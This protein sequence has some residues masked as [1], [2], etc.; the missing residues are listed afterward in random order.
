MLCF[1]GCTEY[2]PVSVI[3]N[4]STV[5][6]IRKL[7]IDAPAEGR[8]QKSLRAHAAEVLQREVPNLTLVESMELADATISWQIFQGHMCVDCGDLAAKGWSWQGEL[9]ATHGGGLVMFSGTKPSSKC[10]PD[11]EFIHQLAKYLQAN[12]Q[13]P[14]VPSHGG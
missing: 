11:D 7:Y 5:L 14:F 8:D 2:Y 3:P 13:A 4:D 9:R 12:S 6:Q 10:C 1:A